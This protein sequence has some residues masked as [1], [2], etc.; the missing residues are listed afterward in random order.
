[1]QIYSLNF[2]NF[3]REHQ[4]MSWIDLHFFHMKTAWQ[5]NDCSHS[6]SKKSVISIKWISKVSLK[7]K[8]LTKWTQLSI[9]SKSNLNFKLFYTIFDGIEN[10][11]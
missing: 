10:P 2:L 4:S 6:K 7:T 1:M 5:T 3:D 8:N 11:S 9:H